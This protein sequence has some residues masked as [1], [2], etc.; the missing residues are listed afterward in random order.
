[1]A[2]VGESDTRL[3]A[4]AVVACLADLATS[5]E[6]VVVY[7]SDELARPRPNPNVLVTGLRDRLPRYRVV[8][9]R[10]GLRTGSLGRDAALFGE[11]VESG[12]VA[13][14]VTPTVDQRGVAA[15]L[16]S[17]LRAD[18]VLLV[19]YTPATGADLHQIW[20]RRNHPRTGTNDG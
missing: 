10:V 5:D 19:S 14:A 9:V 17:Y 12:A 8:A 1:V 6:L 7:G 11:F 3:G 2:V 18:R 4:A 16:S 15:E 20:N 13:I